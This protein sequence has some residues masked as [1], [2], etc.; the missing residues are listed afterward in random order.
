MNVVLTATVPIHELKYVPLTN[1]TFAGRKTAPTLLIAPSSARPLC[2][3]PDG[4]GTIPAQITV[5]L[6]AVIPR[7]SALAGRGA[8]PRYSR[9]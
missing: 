7:T 2:I 9:R 1:R 3:M 4:P 6:K 5:R 8:S